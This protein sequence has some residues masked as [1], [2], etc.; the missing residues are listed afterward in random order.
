MEGTSKPIT[1]K[2]ASE[3]LKFI[4]HSEYSVIEQLN[5]TPARISLLALFQNSEVYRSALLN[6]LG[7]VYVN[8]TIIVEEIDQLVGNIT[9]SA[10][11][12]FT[13][14]EIPLEGRDITKVFHITIKCKSYVMPRA[15]FDNGSSFNVMHMTT[16]SRLPVDL[17]DL[18][19]SQMVV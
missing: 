7:E 16:L 3:F 18:K 19:K 15:L 13:D 9:V 14:K 12:T 1:E 2:K 11:I 17:F 10:C 4:K 5:K 6:A 8:P